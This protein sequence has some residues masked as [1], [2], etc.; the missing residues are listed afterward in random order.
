MS[1][2]EKFEA[3]AKWLDDTTGGDLVRVAVRDIC[4]WIAEQERAKEEIAV[5]AADAEAQ[6]GVTDFHTGSTYGISP[7]TPKATEALK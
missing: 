1:D 3:W 2:R 6:S 4:R 5:T 7:F